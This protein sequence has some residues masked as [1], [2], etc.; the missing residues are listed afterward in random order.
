[1]NRELLEKYYE[2]NNLQVFHDSK[3]LDSLKHL[4]ELETLPEEVRED[5]YNEYELAL[6]NMGTQTYYKLGTL[7]FDK[8]K[9]NGNIIIKD[10][11][12]S[13]TY[14]NLTVQ[15]VNIEIPYFKKI[16]EYLVSINAQYKSVD[17]KLTVLN[18]IVDDF[19]TLQF[20]LDKEKT[21]ARYSIFGSPFFL[22]N[23]RDYAF[24]NT[25]QKP[26]NGISSTNIAS[27]L[28][29]V[30]KGARNSYRSVSSI[31]SYVESL[32]TSFSFELNIDMKEISKK[33]IYNE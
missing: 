3:V 20:L 16:S 28:E 32:L 6:Y 1:M 25:F 19:S 23:D 9:G 13:Y 5:Y 26:Y 4:S 14:N 22:I 7:L 21:E 24:V 11:I 31:K 10:I 15:A 12:N 2:R 27:I 18:I 30:V 17:Y 29:D 8:Y 33:I